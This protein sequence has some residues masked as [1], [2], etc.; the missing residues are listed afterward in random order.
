MAT[1]EQ[2]TGDT[3]D[4]AQIGKDSTVLVAFHGAVPVDQ[5]AF[6]TA[7]STL[8]LQSGFGFSTSAQFVA[9]I[10]AHNAILTCLIEKGLMAAS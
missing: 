3:P 8:A 9:H 5:A 4:G 10:T 6:V 7:T 1:Y 2:I